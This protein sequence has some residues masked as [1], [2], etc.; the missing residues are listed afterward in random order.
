VQEAEVSAGDAG[1]RGNGLA[2]GEVGVVEGKAEL[3]PVAGEDER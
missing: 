1:N 3:V 2:V